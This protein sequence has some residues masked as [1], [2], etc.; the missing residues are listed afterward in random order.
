[1]A[2]GFDGAE[3]RRFLEKLYYSHHE[4]LYR[5]GKPT[6]A[7]VSGSIIGGGIG[8]AAMCNCIVASEDAEFQL[9]ELDVGFVPSFAIAKFP[10]QMS[11]YEAFEMIFTGSEISASEAKEFGFVNRVVSDGDVD[12][13]ARDLASTFARIHPEIMEL[14]HN[15]FMRIHGR[16]FQ[17][18]LWHIIDLLGY[19]VELQSS[20]EG[21]DAFVE[22]RS[23]DW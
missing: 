5:L 3:Q 6:I 22:N 8:L 12:A 1:L 14:A 19:N 21:R 7:A 17:Q 16:E 23:T 10:E 4:Q 13:E 9:T 18:N 20:K 15:A 2:Q 11:H